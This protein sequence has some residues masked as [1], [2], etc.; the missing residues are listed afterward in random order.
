MQC[1]GARVYIQVTAGVYVPKCVYGLQYCLAGSNKLCYP[2]PWPVLV[3][4]LTKECSPLYLCAT[5]FETASYGVPA[6]RDGRASGDASLESCLHE[7]FHQEHISWE[8]PGEKQAKKQLRRS[9]LGTD[10]EAPCTPV[11]GMGSDETTAERTTRRT[12]SF[13]G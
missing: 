3:S 12:V 10:G 1:S 5:S 6:E 13:S 9:S 7:F 11:P 8:C 2:I 4:A